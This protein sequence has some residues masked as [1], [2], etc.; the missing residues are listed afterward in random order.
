MMTGPDIA[1]LAALI[2]D[3]ARANMLLALMGGEALTAS[4]L[5]QEAGVMPQTASAHL[6]KLQNA[7]LLSMEKQGRH[8]YFR[9]ADDAVATA[10]ES[11]MVLSEAVTVK[12]KRRGPKE[13]ALR[14]ARACYDHLAGQMG[15]TLYE[16][17]AEAGCFEISPTAITLTTRGVQTMQVIGIDLDPLRNLRR[18]L[19]RLCLDWSVRRPH[20]AGALG[21]A[22]FDCFLEKQWM[23]RQPGT[24]V[25][26]FSTAG[27]RAFYHL[28]AC[29]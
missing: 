21:A 9:I 2:G 8:R 24:R 15:V 19:C 1:M 28:L 13:P 16:S 5:A 10:I 4:E 7:K 14:K 22:L 6:A 3:P 25:M 29:N 23:R 12:R 20:L 27:E 11:L 18:P 17:L 26:V